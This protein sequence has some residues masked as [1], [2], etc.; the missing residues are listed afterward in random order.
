MAE[1]AGISLSG[2]SETE[3]LSL[4]YQYLYM[5]KVRTVKPHRTKLN[6]NHSTKFDHHRHRPLSSTSVL[7][8]LT[9]CSSLTSLLQADATGGDGIIEEGHDDPY[10]NFFEVELVFL[11][12]GFWC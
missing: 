7:S 9:V 8:C 6:L 3:F 11:V 4:Q 2:C 10:H 5:N 12:K 1:T